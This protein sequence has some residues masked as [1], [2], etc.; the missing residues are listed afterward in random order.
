MPTQ[1]P[2]LWFDGQAEQAARH[3]TTVFPNSEILGTTRYGPGTPGT[4]ADWS[5]VPRAHVKRLWAAVA[6]ELDEVRAGRETAWALTRDAG[7]LA[8]PP[9]PTGVRLLPPGDPYLQKPNRPLLAPDAPVVT[10][11][12]GAPPEQIA[13][14]PLGV[15]AD[16][17]IT[18]AARAEDPMGALR[19]RGDDETGLPGV[20]GS[21]R[22]EGRRGVPI[23]HVSEHASAVVGLHRE[24][25]PGHQVRVSYLVQQPAD[26]VWEQHLQDLRAL[27]RLAAQLLHRGG[28]EQ[29]PLLGEENRRLGG[30][31]RLGRRRS[32]ARAR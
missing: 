7:M 15:F 10:W 26:A 22:L 24:Y 2:C 28:R 1:T 20:D 27:R 19:Q 23:V 11:W 29:L 18:D 17:R 30:R 8:S 9:E 3:Y 5:G 16:R 31:Q 12:Y 13:F 14:D 32:H 21:H 25:D 4:F 6:D